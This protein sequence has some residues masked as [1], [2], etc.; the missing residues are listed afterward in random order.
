MI[1]SPRHA[2]HLIM[3]T[4]LLL[5][6]TAACNRSA[7]PGRQSP[8]QPVTATTDLAAELAG[9]PD[10]SARLT[11]LWAVSDLTGRT[12]ILQHLSTH[13][14]TGCRAFLRARLNDPPHPIFTPMALFCLGQC[15]DPRDLPLLCD[16]LADDS[17]VGRDR[18]QTV[19]GT[20]VFVL[21]QNVPLTYEFSGERFQSDPAY[22]ALVAERYRRWYR[23][24]D[25]GKKIIW[26]KAARRFARPGMPP[27]VLEDHL[28]WLSRLH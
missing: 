27:S 2:H 23:E 19:A 17:A 25:N 20:A 16:L 4:L 8:A 11:A 24:A 7:V 3:A 9:T 10:P 18:N 26:D 21:Q 14:D 22:R 5:G 13:A 6:L 1:C 28:H 15:H 12:R